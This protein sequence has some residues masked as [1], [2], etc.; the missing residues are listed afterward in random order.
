MKCFVICHNVG[1]FPRSNAIIKKLSCTFSRLK[2]VFYDLCPFPCYL[3]IFQ[4][5]DGTLILD[6]VKIYPTLSLKGC[7][8][9]KILN[10]EH[11][12]HNGGT[13]Q[14]LYLNFASV[15]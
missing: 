5:P 13:V 11:T 7:S 2:N 15:T 8:S 6:N 14:A 10:S 9:L 4:S 1:L 12:K 3:V